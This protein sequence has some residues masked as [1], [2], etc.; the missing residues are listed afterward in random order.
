M[1]RVCVEAVC[2]LAV[3]TQ[4]NAIYAASPYIYLEF[5]KFSVLLPLPTF[6]FDLP[7][8]NYIETSL[9]VSNIALVEA[10]GCVV[11][12]LGPVVDCDCYGFI[13]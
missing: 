11:N 2:S 13:L 6:K 8:I 10:F 3:Q 1:R 5:G 9:R 4:Y 7:G 12:Q